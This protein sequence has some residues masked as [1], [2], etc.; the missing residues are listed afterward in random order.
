MMP[1][2]F[3]ICHTNTTA[4]KFPTPFSHMLLG[5]SIWTIK[6]LNFTMNFNWNCPFS[7]QKQTNWFN[8]FLCPHTQNS[9]HSGTSSYTKIAE[10]ELQNCF[11]LVTNSWAL[12]D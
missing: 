5:H 7:L 12:S 1:A 10:L 8:L 6:C 4:T 2:P 9:S 3:F 11:H